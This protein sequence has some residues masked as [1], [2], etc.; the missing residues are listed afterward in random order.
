MSARPAT[1]SPLRR[2]LLPALV[3]AYLGYFGFHAVH[4]SYGLLAKTDIEAVA[5]RLAAEL[6]ELE[7]ERAELNERAALLRPGGIDADLVDELARRDLN[8]I[9][10]DEVVIIP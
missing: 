7:A 8:V 10:P 2:L 4:G 3:A 5:G 1:P 9:A 6:A